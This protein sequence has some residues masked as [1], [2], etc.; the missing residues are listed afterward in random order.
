M[1]KLVK[2]IL[3]SKI[4]Y[5][6]L[7]LG[8]FTLL[9]LFVFSGA[10]SLTKI[11]KPVEEKSEFQEIK[12]AETQGMT[13]ATSLLKNNNLEIEE[14]TTPRHPYPYQTCSHLNGLNA[15]LTRAYK[16]TGEHTLFIQLYAPGMAP[17]ALNEYKN[18]LNE[19]WNVTTS[20]QGNPETTIL[21]YGDNYYA[22]T[23]GDAIIFGDA[24]LTHYLNQV[25]TSLTE[26]QCLDLTTTSQDS[27]RNGYS[28]P[29][30]YTGLILEETI[31]YPKPITYNTPVIPQMV[32][33]NDHITQ[34]E[35]PFPDNAPQ[36]PEPV[37]TPNIG[38]QEE[39]KTANDFSQTIN[40][41]V[42]DKRGPGCGWAWSAYKGTIEDDQALYTAQE[43]K[44]K[45]A[46]TIVKQN[47]QT[48]LNGQDQYNIDTLFELTQLAQWN[49]Y[50]VEAN[51]VYDYWYWL[52]NERLKFKPEW[53]TYIAN[54]QLWLNAYNTQ[55]EREEE[56]EKNMVEYEQCII[57]REEALQEAN[58]A[59]AE[60]EDQVRKRNEQLQEPEEEEPTL[61]PSDDPSITPTPT[62]TPTFDPIPAPTISIPTCKKPEPV[63]PLWDKP[64]QPE[65]PENIT[66]PDSWTRIDDLH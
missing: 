36:L 39:Y 54:Y 18:K 3:N 12:Q 49:S 32:T 25:S 27:Q 4:F 50:A 58:E 46:Q 20:T 40:Y 56:Y 23:Y 5:T 14:N 16:G 66:I 35:N 53:D 52:N 19:C 63:T 26:S 29:E 43:N 31:K 21:H 48:Y 45:E 6:L 47:V 59:Q 34:P 17:A 55:D 44:R 13:W 2:R 57:D 51:N 11:V 38:T 62:P 22:F 37:T 28:N 15:N 65:I 7:F 33:L 24:N 42:P 1:K 41:R 60:Y 61:T 8:L 30:N 9:G 10:Q 64:T